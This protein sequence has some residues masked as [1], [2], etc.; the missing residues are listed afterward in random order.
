MNQPTLDGVVE[1]LEKLEAVNGRL[2]RE[3]DRW[4]RGGLVATA[5]A[6]VLAIAGAGVAARIAPKLE[7]NEF[8]LRDKAGKTR[9][10]LTIRPDGTPGFALFDADEKIRLSLDLGAK[11]NDSPGVNIYGVEGDLR[12]PGDPARRHPGAG[13]LRQ[14]AQPAAVARH[15]RGRRGRPEPLRRTGRAAGGPGDPARWRAWSGSLQPAR[16]GRSF[17]RP[18]RGGRDLARP[19]PLTRMKNEGPVDAGQVGLFGNQGLI[20]WT[21]RPVPNSRFEELIGLLGYQPESG[22][23]TMIGADK[24]GWAAVPGV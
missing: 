22:C 5:G 17:H 18:R 21:L 10:A 13:F 24:P 14:A 9:A 4:R 15:E 16:A 7:A 19:G 8:V 3:C 11:D 6:V 2:R 1:R 12:S 20:M 23:S